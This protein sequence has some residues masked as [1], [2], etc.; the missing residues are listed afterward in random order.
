VVVFAFS[1]TSHKIEYFQGLPQACNQLGTPAG[2]KCFL[3]G[4]KFF[5][6]CPTHFSSGGEK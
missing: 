5:Q 3:R 4:A 1:V 2:T 6:L